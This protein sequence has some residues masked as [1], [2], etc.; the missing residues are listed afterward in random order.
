ME[1]DGKLLPYRPVAVTLGK[2]VNNGWGAYECC[3]AR[4]LLAVLVGALE[5]PGGIWVPRCVSTARVKTGIKRAAGTGRLHAQQA[6][7]HI[8]GQVAKGAQWTQ[9]APHLG[10]VRC[11]GNSGGLEPITGPFSPGLDVPNPCAEELATSTAPDIWFAYRTNPSISFWDTPN[12]AKTITPFRLPYASP[13]RRTRPTTWP[14]SCFPIPP[15]WNP[16]SLSAWARPVHG[17]VLG[18]PR[19]RVASTRGRTAGRRARLHLDRY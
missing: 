12:V 6:Q 17:A 2:T 18:S 8:Q 13:T 11:R 9:C 7:S 14:T 10:A 15:T 3:W 1:V 4:T 16:P 5:V 19:L